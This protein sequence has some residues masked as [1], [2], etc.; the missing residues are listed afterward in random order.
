MPKLERVPEPDIDYAYGIFLLKRKHKLIRALRK[1]YQPMVHG[2]KTWG[3]SFLVMD[4]LAHTGVAKGTKAMEIGCG[5]GSLSVFCAHR[6]KAKVTAVDL[7]PAVFPYVDVFAEI[8]GVKVA[9]QQSDFTKLKAEEL[10]RYGLIMGS[11]ICFWDSL[12]EP[13]A[14]LVNRAIKGGTRRIVIADPGRP[15]F[16]EL[17]DRLAK[18]HDVKLQEWYSIEPERFEGEI[19]EVNPK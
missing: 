17:C 1:R 18:R 8:N 10:G 13:L 11:D 4:Y 16:Y 9:T 15:T 6:F 2:H 14:R 19:V 12:V 7:D 5:W 3:S